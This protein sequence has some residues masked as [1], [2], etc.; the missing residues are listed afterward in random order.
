MATAAPAIVSAVFAFARFRSNTRQ[1]FFADLL[2][3]DGQPDEIFWSAPAKSYHPPKIDRSLRSRDCLLIHPFEQVFEAIEPVSPEAG[4]LARPVD[5]RGQSAEL[6]TI[7]GLPTFV[8]VADQP[9][10]LE[11]RKML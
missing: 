11:D 9:G 8:A 5:Q 7:M 1:R 2:A 10:L 6:C 4:H 3:V